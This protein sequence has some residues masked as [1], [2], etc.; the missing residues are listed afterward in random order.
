MSAKTLIWP[1]GASV[2]WPGHENLIGTPTPVYLG[3][4]FSGVENATCDTR[5][6]TVRIFAESH[7]NQNS[8]CTQ[9]TTYTPIFT[10]H[11]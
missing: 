5:A 10:H 9:K 7:S 2:P 8:R 11:I 1:Y 6:P 3:S 4:R